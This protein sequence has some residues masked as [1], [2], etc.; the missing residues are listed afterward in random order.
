M[1]L[2][3]I[4]T[5]SKHYTRPSDFVHD[6]LHL[7]HEHL[8]ATPTVSEGETANMKQLRSDFQQ[9]IATIVRKELST[10]VC[11]CIRDFV[12]CAAHI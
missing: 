9:Y 12:V 7:T 5:S 1:F 8:L 2:D 11:T 10:E 4:K 6:V 3:L